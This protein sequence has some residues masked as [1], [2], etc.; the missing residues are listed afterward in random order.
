MTIWRRVAEPD[1][2]KILAT[3]PPN[4]NRAMYLDAA[5][6]VRYEGKGVYI[7]TDEWGDEDRRIMSALGYEPF[8]WES[9]IEHA[10]SDLSS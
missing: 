4:E 5:G 2:E 3:V 10:L 9:D 1:R 7:T 6:I 8:T